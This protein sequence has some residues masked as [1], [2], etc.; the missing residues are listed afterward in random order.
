MDM[1]VDRFFFDVVAEAT[2]PTQVTRLVHVASE[3]WRNVLTSDIGFVAVSFVVAMIVLCTLAMASASLAYVLLYLPWQKYLAYRRGEK[4]RRSRRKFV[5]NT[6][7]DKVTD[8]LDDLLLEGTFNRAEVQE[9]TGK[10]GRAFG[11]PDLVP[12]IPVKQRVFVLKA[13]LRRKYADKLGYLATLREERKKEAAQPLT[14]MQRLALQR[15][16]G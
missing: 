4:M 16:V 15:K 13:K 2:D 9:L 6:V 8:L 12:K 3:Y 1:F 10:L 11:I 14:F 7:A 5:E